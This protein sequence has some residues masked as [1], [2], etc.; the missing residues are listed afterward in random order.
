MRP[1]VRS[2]TLITRWPSASSRSARCEPMNPAPPVTR[3]VRHGANPRFGSAPMSSDGAFAPRASLAAPTHAIIAALS[4]HSS[5]GGNEHPQARRARRRAPAARAAGCSRRRPPPSSTVLDVEL[6]RRLDRLGHLHVDDRLLEARRQVGHDR[7]RGPP[8]AP[9]SRAAAR[10]SSTRSSRSRSRPNRSI[11]RGNRIAFGI[12]GRAPAASSAGPPGNPSPSSRA[13]LSNASPAASSS[14]WPS[15]SWRN[16]SGM[17]TI[18]VWP[19]LTTSATY[20][21]SGGPCARKFAQ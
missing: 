2:S 5:S 14:V 13:T 9:P 17:C 8:R 6:P 21:G 19:P 18:I 3:T 7:C 1:V 20:G 12:A 4:V 15:T 16:S 10:P 11:A